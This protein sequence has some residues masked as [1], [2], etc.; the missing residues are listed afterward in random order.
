MG[1]IEKLLSFVYPYK[2]EQ[3]IKKGDKNIYV[4][5]NK[6][7]GERIVIYNGFVYSRY[8]R[9]SVYTKSYWDMLLPLGCINGTQRILMIGLG[10][11]TIAYQMERLFGDS[12]HLDIIEIDQDMIDITK[13]LYPGIKADVV[14]GDGA[15]FIKNRHNEYDAIIIDAYV[16]LG[17]PGVFL[18]KDFI[19]NMNS[20][21]KHD[22]IVGINFAQTLKNSGQFVEYSK[23]L[24]A[25][26][27]VYIVNVSIAADNV[28]ILC[29]KRLDKKE[30]LSRIEISMQ[31]NKENRHIL[32]NYK[33]MTE[34]R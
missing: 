14:L 16:N 20:A 32:E 10:G 17:I 18:S 15:E 22:G 7:N 24:S 33:K 25:L 1:I 2:E 30:I 12:V 34:F 6:K 8:P 23:A 28:I 27:K 26:F 5:K 31:E 11:G 19:S 3:S 13:K 9:D 4:V 21:L 29:S